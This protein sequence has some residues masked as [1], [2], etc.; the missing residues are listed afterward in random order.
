VTEPSSWRNELEPKIADHVRYIVDAFASPDNGGTDIGVVVAADRGLDYM[1]KER[2]LLVHE[3]QL[4]R[5]LEILGQPNEADLEQNE[6]DR[7]QR[8]IAGV[9]LLTLGQTT[10]GDQ[11]AAVPDA[12][13]EI[14]RRIGKGIATPNH[15]LTVAVNA[16]GCPATEP[17]EAYEETEPYPSVCGDNG[18]AG[19]LIYMAD[20]GLLADAASHSWLEGVVGDPDPLPPLAPDGTQPIPPYTGHGTF[21]AGV[22]RCM[23]PAAD[24]TVTNAFAIAG[25]T[26][27]SDLVPRLVAALGLGVDIFHLTIAAPS[28]D[29]LPLVA[30]EAWLKLLRQY[31]GV[32]CVV[33]A[34]NS[35]SRRPSWPAAFSEVVSV[36]ALAADWRSRASFSNF[37]GWVDVYAPGR[38]L[39]NAYATGT[40][41]CHV[42]PYR[43]QDRTF[44]GMAKWSGT[45]FSTP[46]F[47]GLIAARM[48]RTGENGQQA[49]A[50]L[51]AEAR[52]RAIPGVGAIVLPCCHDDVP[53]RPAEC[54]CRSGM[55]RTG[56][57]PRPH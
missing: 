9:V 48:S 37:G 24:V 26:L 57:E 35:G 29:D 38:S 55:R 44:Y 28:R 34:G 21:V 16:G 25:S 27:E 36:G 51:L 56:C 8:V 5:V 12:L 11:P 15:V 50:A 54:P 17:Q 6:P 22:T 53:V 18:G 43:G 47:T 39:V 46:I 52:S 42:E 4:G 3:Q 41:T 7:V 30:F 1:Y 14:D 19:V 31:K 49:A 33:A 2:Q 13:I 23:A 40:Y 10:K 20:T 45:S 32:V